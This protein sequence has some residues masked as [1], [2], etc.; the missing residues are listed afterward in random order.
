MQ[1]K[2]L[3]F[4]FAI[5]VLVSV[6]ASVAPSGG[7]AA[8]PGLA[9]GDDS[10]PAWI[11][12]KCDSVCGLDDPLQLSNPAR[13]DH[14]ALVDL[15]PEIE[16]LHREGIDPRSA[17]GIQLLQRAADRVRDEC[18]VV[19]VAEGHCSV[20]KRIRHRDGRSVPDLTTLVGT[21]IRPPR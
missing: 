15:T 20:W 3:G 13:V 17:A 6:C 2:S 16:K 9:L 4:V 12:S 11:A 10:G 19:R 7:C 5:A 21:R 18:E 1:Q 14:P 8:G